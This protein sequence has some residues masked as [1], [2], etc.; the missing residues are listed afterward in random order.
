[1]AI[2]FVKN[3]IRS[4]IQFIA[5][6]HE[7]RPF[8]QFLDFRGTLDAAA[9]A[10]LPVCE[11]IERKHCS[12]PPTPRAETMQRLEAVGVFDRKIDRVCEIGPGAGRYLELTMARCKP[13]IY[14][15]YE[16]SDE[17][18]S[19]LVREHQAVPRQTDGRTL[20]E[21]ESGSVGL[22][23]A[24]KLFPGLPLLVTLSYLSEMARVARPGGW[25]V[26]DIISES[27]MDAANLK[28]WLDASP[29]EWEWAP[30]MIALGYVKDLLARFDIEF[31]DG[32]RVPLFPAVT[33]C[34]V[35]RRKPA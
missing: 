15:I 4:T 13:E 14:E 22:V 2:S 16:T 8:S 31:V 33:E 1:M 19:W 11:Y 10:G 29:W 18:R 12:G 23:Q 34:L 6:K 24:H 32:F 7:P 21:T 20:A 5:H 9:A 3:P 27:C 17:W 28:L 26:F 25:I 35:F 30:H